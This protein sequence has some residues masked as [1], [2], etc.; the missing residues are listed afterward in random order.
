MAR[1]KIKNNN[2]L[3][4]NYGKSWEYIK[5]SKKFILIIIT[6]FFFFTLVGFFI[7]APS[8]ISQLISSYTKDIINQTSGLSWIQLILFI[9]FN[10]LKTSFFGLIL[11][12]FFGIFPSLIAMVLGFVSNESVKANGVLILWKLFPHGI[13]ELPA[14]FISLGLGLALASKLFK[15]KVKLGNNFIEMLRVFLFVVVPLLVIAAI[16]EGTLIFLIH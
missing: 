11:G 9:F 1:K 14:V 4:E 5:E 7:P 10:N 16:I 8:Y 13:F 3:F 2:V 15:K 12:I 6:I